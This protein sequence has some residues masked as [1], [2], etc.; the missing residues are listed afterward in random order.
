MAILNLTPHSIDVYAEGNFVNLEQVNPTTWTAEG[1]KGEAIASFPSVGSVRV[2][3]KTVEADPLEGIPCVKSLYGEIEGVPDCT[4]LDTL[5]VSLPSIAMAKAAG[6]PI[7]S[8]M[9]APYKV[10]RLASNTSQV[11]GCMGF[12]Y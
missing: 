9:V 12:T 5:I 6:M 3:V 8:Q 7:A 1:I 10:V 2:Q 4:N 11:L